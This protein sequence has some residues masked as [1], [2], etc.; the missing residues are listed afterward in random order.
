MWLPDLAD[1]A[2]VHDV[3]S[4]HAEALGVDG[5]VASTRLVDV[6]LTN[7]HRPE[8]SRCRGWATY[9]VPLHEGSSV[10][11][12]L[13]GYPDRATSEAAWRQDRAARPS[14]RS[15]HLAEQDL[16]VWRFP[17]DPQLPTLPDLI[18][19]PLAPHVVPAAVGA[20][21]GPP[22]E[23]QVTVVR[24]QPEASATLRVE[25]AQAGG[26]TA[27]AKHLGAGSVEDVAARHLALWSVTGPGEPLRV[28]EP[29]AADLVDRALWTR[30]VPGPTVTEAVPAS[31]LAGA[32]VTIGALLAA[33]HG[34][35]IGPTPTMSVDGLLAEM[36]KK[37]AKLAHAHPAVEPIVSDLLAAATRRHSDVA[38]GRACTLHGDFHLDQLVASADG[39]V[40][41]DLDTIVQGP[42]E[43]DLAEFLVDLALRA[44]PEGVAEEVADQLLS[45]YDAATGTGVD[46]ALLAVCADAEF[47]NRCYRHLRRH[48]PGWQ[49][50]LEAELS[51]HGD[52][53]RLLKR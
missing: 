50:E 30:G 5:E 9:V 40:L 39:P 6:R 35:A 14:G 48:T 43:V 32:T 34:S 25:G 42:P 18:A 36:R 44:L 23:L 13:K 3:V 21:L 12:Y 16:V 33:L 22:S 2:W 26:P 1:A 19:S 8:S 46:A 17:E 51:R 7:P 53:A 37:T 27:F 38:R 28:A 11:L 45:S 31:E 10:Q 29:L 24:Y 41:V 15:I 47:V 52:V 4:R 49:Q 20:A